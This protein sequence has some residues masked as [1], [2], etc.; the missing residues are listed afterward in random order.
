LSYKPN[1]SVCEASAGV[2]LARRLRDAG[3]P[4]IVYDPAALDSARHVLG[5]SVAYAASTIA[6]ARQAEV[7]VVAVAWSEFA[8]LRPADMRRPNHRPMVIDCWRLLNPLEFA[9]VANVIVLGVGPPSTLS[10]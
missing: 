6:C 5:H 9:S 3:V 7:L 2:G 8:T 10:A 1:T 4:V